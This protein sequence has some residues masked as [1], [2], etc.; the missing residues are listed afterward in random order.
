MVSSTVRF[1]VGAKVRHA[2]FDGV[3]FRRADDGYR[4]MLGRTKIKGSSRKVVQKR[5]TL[6]TINSR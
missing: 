6:R 3:V 5:R 2:L 4:Y 1:S